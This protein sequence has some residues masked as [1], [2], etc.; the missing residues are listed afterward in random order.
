MKRPDRH[1]ASSLTPDGAGVGW[2]ISAE[3][4]ASPFLQRR[5]QLRTFAPSPLPSIRGNRP[6][7]LCRV[8]SAREELYIGVSSPFYIVLVTAKEAGVWHVPRIYS[9]PRRLAPTTTGRPRGA[10]TLA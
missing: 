9:A 7:A 4:A 3:S 1:I 5:I 6:N 8:M 2:P 10:Q